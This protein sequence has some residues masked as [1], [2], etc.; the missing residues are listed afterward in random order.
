MDEHDALT[1]RI[2]GCAMKV[3]SAL[4]PGL[5]ESAYEVCLEHELKKA[6]LTV[7]RQVSVPVVYDGIHLDSGYRIDLP[8][9]DEVILELK[10]LE[11]LLPV[12]EAQLL[13]Y[14]RLAKKPRG[15]LINFHAASLKDGIVRRSL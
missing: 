9:N 3:H 14:I 12:H 4:G 7:R 10:V 8:V 6:G 2:I 13:S 5:L 15:L 11:H 1:H